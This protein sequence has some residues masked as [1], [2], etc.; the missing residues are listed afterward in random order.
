VAT[1]CAAT[2]GTKLAKLR[3]P[4]V[5]ATLTNMKVVEMA[6]QVNQEAAFFL[7]GMARLFV[8]RANAH[9]SVDYEPLLGDSV[10]AQAQ[11]TGANPLE[12]AY[13]AMLANDGP[14]GQERRQGPAVLPGVQLQL[15]RPVA[16]PH[17]LQHP[18]TMMSL[19]DGGAHVGYVCDV[20]MPT[21]MLTHWARDRTRGPKLPL[22]LLV[23][24]QTRD[25]AQVYGLHDRGLLAPGMKA[26][27]NIIDFTRLQLDLPHFV[28]DLPAGGRRLMLDALKAR[29]GAQLLHRDGRARAAWPRRIV[30]E[31]PPPAAVV[32]AESTAR[33][34][35]CREAGQPVQGAGDSVWRGL[36][37]RRPSAGRAGRHQHRRG[38]HEQG[39][40]HQRR[41]P[42]GD[43]A[44]RRDAQGSSTKR[45]RAPACSSPSTPA[46]TP[47][48]GGMSATRA[49]GTNAVRYGTMREN[50]LALEVV[51]ASGEVIRTGTRA[52]KS[53]AGYD[54]TRLMVG[55]EGTLG[56]ITEVT[57]RIYPLPEAVSPPSAR[58]PASRRR[59]AP[60]SR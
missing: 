38:P 39:A 7:R 4:Q 30:F 19:A 13:D 9:G 32:F 17:E 29:F 52:K 25:T 5:R 21:F 15:R 44:A 31:A 48:I 1:D 57:L 8:L 3:E 35:R 27:V 18:R 28:F 11:K 37:A 33:R 24:K 42:D 46:P 16:D 26:D 36:L 20:S 54:L 2:L 41:R 14:G 58:S 10:V 56:V 43:G 23:K 55:S 34:G 60:P 51:T 59:C 12:I 50:V 53:S 49:S 22:E 47:R 6:A 40:E 45:S